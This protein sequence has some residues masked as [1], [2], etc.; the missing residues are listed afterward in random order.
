MASIPPPIWTPTKDQI[1]RSN[2]YRYMR[3]LE[4]THNRSF[5]RYIDLW[6]W[7]VQEPGLFWGS[8]WDYFEVTGDR[9]SPV[10]LEQAAMPGAQ[11][12]P[13]ARLNYAEQVFRQVRSGS[14]AI[15]FTSEQSADLLEITWDALARQVSALASWFI[16]QG[17]KPGDRIAAFLPAIPEATI[18][19]LACNAVGAIWSS[20]SPDFGTG[21]VL[22]RFQQIEPTILIAASS[23]QYGGKTFSRHEVIQTLCTELSSLQHL[24]LLPFHADDMLEEYS[25]PVSYWEAALAT[26]APP[27][28]TF[29]RMPFD[30]PIW[31]LYS[32]GT[33]GPPKAIAHSQGGILLEHLKYLAFH[34]DLHPGERY[35]WYSTTGWMMWNF[36]QSALLTG[37][38]LVLYDGSPTYPT[39]DRL[40]QLADQ[41]RLHH[42]GT[43]APFLVACMK[44][45][46]EPSNR[47]DL[48]HLRSI[49]S[50]GSPLPPE[51]FDYTLGHIKPGVW[52]CSISG[53]TDM[54]TAFV[55]GCPIEPL[56]L[57][58]IQCRT[59]GCAMEA[60][61]ESGTPLL[62]EI[63]EMVIDQPMPS[64]PVFFWNDPEMKRYKESYFDMYPGKWRH[65][66]WVKIT[67]RGSLQIFGR[68]DATLNRQGI[69]I[70][71]AEIYRSVDKIPEIADSLIV[72][73][74]L[75]GGGHF[76]P[77]FVLL[78][79]GNSLD[80]SLRKRIAQ[81]L[82]TDYSPRHVPDVVI[83]VA[84]IP[85]TISGKKMEMPVK[86]ILMGKNPSEVA[87]PDAMR[88]PESLAFFV[89][90]RKEVEK[91]G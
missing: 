62:D 59:L 21:S 63:G 86:R 17:I 83:E 9:P 7:S 89:R 82:R 14:P 78:N 16:D 13:E 77:L 8:L 73:L 5:P 51:A 25:V 23:Y 24:L 20:C 60:L 29:V 34:N 38:T 72:N 6:S 46:L 30:H 15:L 81:Q 84:A 42:F 28:P 87:S 71:T 70:G 80:E 69:R 53:G 36:A 11:W 37:A 1:E 10:V 45:G 64:M 76:M 55:G 68:S 85:Y 48:S 67:P 58:E 19:F 75:P 88:N 61:D 74:E 2:L 56:Y 43:S 44:A 18:A 3:W 57:G 27:S 33:T 26:P 12:F 90:F 50:T 79:P 32:S 65:G 40:W 52:L 4:T 31:V 41:S 47:Y 35:F 22:E 39:L 66:D 49:G 54:C 91:R